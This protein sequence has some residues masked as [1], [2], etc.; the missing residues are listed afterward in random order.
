LD[1]KEIDDLLKFGAYD[2]FREEEKENE[3]EKKF[4]EEDIDQILNR[5]EKV[6]WNESSAK[7]LGGASSFSKASFRSAGEPDIDIN[8]PN[9]WTKVLPGTA[10]LSSI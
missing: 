3:K 1:K 8:D 7:V 4:Y 2:L 5:S 6:V 10:P 9:F